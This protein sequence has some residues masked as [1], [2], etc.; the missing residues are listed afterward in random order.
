MTDLDRLGKR[1]ARLQDELKAVR[2]ELAPLI[3]DEHANGATYAQLMTR[4]GY[5]SIETIR[6]ICDPG[7][8]DTIN[9][10]RRGE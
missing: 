7:A 4:A 8:R 5:K 10:R 9:R 3:R 6:Q 1:H 2:A